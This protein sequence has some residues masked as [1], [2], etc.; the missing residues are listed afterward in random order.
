MKFLKSM[1]NIEWMALFGIVAILS[2]M[3]FAIYA[4]FNH[5]N[6]TNDMIEWCVDEGGVPV[7]V[8]NQFRICVEA[9][10]VISR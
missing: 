7:I 4:G 3:S 10:A 5:S 9:D 8:E 2:I 1:E 6:Y